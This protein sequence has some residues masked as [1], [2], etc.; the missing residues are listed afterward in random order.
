VSKLG[1]PR[2]DVG[3]CDID[4]IRDYQEPDGHYIRADDLDEVIAR[5][6][7]LVEAMDVE[8]GFQPWEALKAELRKLGVKVQ[9][10][11]DPEVQP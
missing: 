2:W 6:E 9:L 4:G 5:I 7:P 10:C 8:Q 11:D 1:L 3:E